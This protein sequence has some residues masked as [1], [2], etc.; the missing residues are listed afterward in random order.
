MTQTR[1]QVPGVDLA[2]QYAQIR[3]D[4]DSAI[5]RVLDRTS[6]ILG[7]EV[8][9]FE[10]AFAAHVGARGAVG[11]SSG[12]AALQLALR[13]LGVGAGDEVITTA[14]TFIA[15]AEAISNIGAI[16]V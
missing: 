9:N 6:F 7:A 12:T 4:I 13:V 5:Q 10:T 2:A 8:E 16:P 14:H 3:P 15:T 1:I 11:V